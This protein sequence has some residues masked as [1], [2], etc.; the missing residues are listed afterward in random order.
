M[1]DP[2]DVCVP[3]GN[4]GNIL[5][6]YLARRLGL[7]IANLICASNEVRALIKPI[8]PIFRTES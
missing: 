2:V 4:F 8:L 1:G 6:V 7:P 3:S 5:G